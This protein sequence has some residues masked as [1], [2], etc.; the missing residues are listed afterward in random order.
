MGPYNEALL[1]LK[2]EGIGI[3]ISAFQFRFFSSWDD[4]SDADMNK[5]KY[6]KA[7][8]AYMDKDAANHL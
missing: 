2:Y 7:Y 6:F 4:I 5:I 1:I 3:I 8:K